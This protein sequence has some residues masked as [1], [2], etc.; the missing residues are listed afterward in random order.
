MTHLVEPSQE[1]HASL[2]TARASLE[3]QRRLLEAQL[4]E[5]DAA[6]APRRHLGNLYH[7]PPSFVPPP[8][9]SVPPTRSRPRPAHTF[10]R[11]HAPGREHRSSHR[12]YQTMQDAVDRLNQASSSI[13]VALDPPVPRIA[14]PYPVAQEYSGEAAVNQANR[15][16]AKRRKL[17]DGLLAKDFGPSY[18]YR[19]QVV[20]GPLRLEIV[21]CDGGLYEYGKEKHCPENVL[22][23]DLSVY[24]TRTSKC[25]LVLRHE[26][27]A[28]FCLRKLV[29][30]APETGFTAPIQE[31]M[32]FVAMDLEGLIRKAS[33]YTIRESPGVSPNS[34]RSSSPSS[35]SSPDLLSDRYPALDSTPHGDAQYPRPPSRRR[36]EDGTDRVIPPPVSTSYVV[37]RDGDDNGV[38]Q[39]PSSR[40]RPR[41]ARNLAPHRLF[42]RHSPDLPPGIPPSNIRFVQSDFNVSVDCENHSDDEE[43]ES[44]EATLAD[45]YYRDRIPSPPDSSDELEDSDLI[46]RPG[47]RRRQGISSRR[48]GRR[49]APRRIEIEDPIA[50]RDGDLSEGKDNSDVLVPHATIFIEKRKSMVN[51]KF[52]PPV[53][54]RYVLLKLWSP[55][56]DQNID[57]QSIIAHGFAGPR[58]FPATRFM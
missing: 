9:H 33:R 31:G 10:Q 32:V 34:S 16:R 36:T 5:T 40:I 53:S 41:A 18:G 15:Q 52:D 50:S 17:N 30:K 20:P 49:L 22:R 28:P 46:Y 55:S 39:P 19:G 21:F 56:K 37:S 3:S 23:N 51:V 7:P 6:I 12:A 11:P 26:G 14:S 2:Q 58:F 29:I 57:I 24:C 25:D 13:S 44:S 1:N 45:R 43:E 35:P 54:G 8:P 38:W 42:D 48:Q 27:G 4:E 47:R